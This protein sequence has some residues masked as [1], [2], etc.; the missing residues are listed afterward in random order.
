MSLQII[1]NDHPNGRS[2]HEVLVSPRSTIRCLKLRYVKRCIHHTQAIGS[3]LQSQAYRLLH[4]VQAERPTPSTRPTLSRS[5]EG[6]DTS[7]ASCTA[8]G[9]DVGSPKRRH[10]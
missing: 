2:L 8:L 1:E 4:A 10:I 7:K 9:L 6:D 5:E 3:D